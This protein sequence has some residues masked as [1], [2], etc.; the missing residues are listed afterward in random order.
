MATSARKH[1]VPAEGETPRYEAIS[2]LGASVNDIVPVANVTA[3]AQLVTDLVD[4]G[5]GPT[6]ARP[7][8]VHRSDASA[9]RRLESTVDGTTWTTHPVSVG[10]VTTV[11]F[12]SSGNGTLTH[13]LGWVPSAF[14]PL[15]QTSSSY[16]NVLQVYVINNT[17]T[18]S[19]VQLRARLV[20]NGGGVSGYVGTLPI[21]WL[22]VG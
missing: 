1:T 6:T 4:I 15:P 12:D 3:R 2:E 9:A 20:A 11:T 10:N 16:A 8:Y 5:Q 22:A 19:N 21:A 13:N 18:M 17:I 7:L 14:I